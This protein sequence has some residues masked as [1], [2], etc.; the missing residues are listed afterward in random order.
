MMKYLDKWE[1]P[2]TNVCKCGN[3]QEAKPCATVKDANGDVILHFLGIPWR[4]NKEATAMATK[5]CE[6]VNKDGQDNDS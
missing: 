3:N 6:R 1:Y 2:L 4:S 5:F